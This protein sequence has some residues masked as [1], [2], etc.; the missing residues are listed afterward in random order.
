MIYMITE[1]DTIGSNGWNS[2]QVTVCSDFDYDDHSVRASSAEILIATILS[3]SHQDKLV[4]DDWPSLER[5][6]EYRV[7]P[8]YE[9]DVS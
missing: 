4:N 8:Q 6:M 9:V 1:I 3:L 2:T 7:R 5:S